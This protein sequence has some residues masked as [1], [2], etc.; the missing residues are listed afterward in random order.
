MDFAE[1][2]ARIARWEN[3]HTEFKEGLIRPDD[4]AAG[5]VA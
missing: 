3:L 1:L 2:Q 4:L 5:L